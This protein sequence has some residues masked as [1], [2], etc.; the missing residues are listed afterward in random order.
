MSA[1]SVRQGR[2]EDFEAMREEIAAAI[3]PALVVPGF[4]EAYHAE[5]EQIVASVEAA[6][7]QGL[8][9]V[10]E[11]VLVGTFGE[12][13]AGFLIL[14]CSQ[15]WPEIRWIVVLP[16]H[17]GRGLAQAL[18]EAVL[19]SYGAEGELRLIVTH[20]NERAIRF[21]RRYGFVEG[22]AG[23]SARRV[24]R[25]RRAPAALPGSR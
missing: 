6:F 4:D 2:V 24:L 10:G 22:P 7:T 16:E 18:M 21:F 3:H 5:T 13:P 15:G 17:I 20:Y 25:M 11:R 1:Y 19:G 8:S 12:A 23:A 14:D 9:R